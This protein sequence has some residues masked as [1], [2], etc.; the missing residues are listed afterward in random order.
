MKRLLHPL[1]RGFRREIWARWLRGNGRNCPICGGSFRRFIRAGVAR[2]PDAQCPRCG[3]LERH[4]AF[5]CYLTE[6]DWES[7][8]MTVLHFAPEACLEAG[9]R[10]NPNWTYQ[11]ADLYAPAD[12]RLDLTQLKRA[13]ASYDVLIAHHVLPEIE[14]DVQALQEI[15][16]VLRPGG[17]CLT[18]NPLDPNRQETLHAHDLAPEARIQRWGGYAHLYRHGYGLDFLALLTKIGF[19]VTVWKPEDAVS[20]DAFRSMR[21]HGWVVCAQ[22]PEDGTNP[23]RI[24]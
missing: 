16:R 13:D 12:W 7:R 10:A 6:T 18:M 1:W 24:R 9:F 11:T 23:H 5:A 19:N 22:K 3:S 2:R 15:F 17:V 8:T 4:R 14:D 20:P 21:L